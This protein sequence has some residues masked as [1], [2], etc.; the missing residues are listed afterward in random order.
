VRGVRKQLEEKRIFKESKQIARA[1]DYAEAL[2][3]LD[4]EARQLGE[5]L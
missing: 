5:R 3:E 1:M 2:N 4:N